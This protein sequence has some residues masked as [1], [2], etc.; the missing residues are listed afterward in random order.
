MPR[1]LCLECIDPV[2]DEYYLP[3]R[4]GAQTE[5]NGG[6]ICAIKEGT[7]VPV[8]LLLAPGRRIQARLLNSDDYRP[9]PCILLNNPTEDSMAGPVAPPAS[10]ERTICLMAT[11]NGGT[12]FEDLPEVLQLNTMPVSPHY[13]AQSRRHVHTSPEWEKEN[14]WVILHAYDPRKPFQGHWRNLA[15]QNPNQSS[16]RLDL[17][18]LSMVHELAKV[19]KL[20]WEEYCAHDKEMRRRC[21]TEYQA[22][23]HKLYLARRQSSPT[24]ASAS[25]SFSSATIANIPRSGQP[26]ATP[27]PPA[28]NTVRGAD[29]AQQPRRSFAEVA[30]SSTSLPASEPTLQST[31]R[32][33][34]AA[35]SSSVPVVETM[36]QPIPQPHH[37]ATS[38]APSY[39]N[40]VKGNRAVAAPTPS[41]A[42]TAWFSGVRGTISNVLRGKSTSPS[43]PQ[44]GGSR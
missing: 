3:E 16:F 2:H 33:N 8:Y 24:T 12:K 34:V 11:F 19:R 26:L 39:A 21:Y 37:V 20:Q 38:N 9:R 13:L 28:N 29:T 4:R 43:V 18:A 14:A 36:L 22:V 15:S 30:R 6:D 35:A 41:P 17:E 23:R 7:H 5:Y 1:V 42:R 40:A 31:S 25:G 10:V 44:A 27:S 32:S